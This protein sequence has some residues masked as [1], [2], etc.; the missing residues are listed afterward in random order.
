[1]TPER[2]P[3]LQKF[4]RFVGP[5]PTPVASFGLAHRPGLRPVTPTRPSGIGVIALEAAPRAFTT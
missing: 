2:N 3:L 5:S 4:H 1:M